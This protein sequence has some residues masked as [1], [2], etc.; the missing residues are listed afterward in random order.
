VENISHIAVPYSKALFMLAEE[1]NIL[2]DVWRDMLVIS[3]LCNSNRDFLLMLKSPVINT[4]KKQK[5]IN[6]ILKDVLTPVTMG[7]MRILIDRK[8]ESF[9]RDISIAFIELYK[10]HMGI[11]TTVVKT[12][13][14]VSDELRKQILEVMKTQTSGEVELVEEVNKELIGGFLLQWKD[15]QYDASILKQ[16]ND[17]RRETAALNLYIKGF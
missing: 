17:L 16:I 6:A 3:S 7:F 4:E 13:V 8:R 2:G 12:A 1:R 14:P 10:D 11:L 15:K 9:I 5:I